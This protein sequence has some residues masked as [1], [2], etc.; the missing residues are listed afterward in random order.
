MEQKCFIFEGLFFVKWGPGIGFK[1]L[2]LN[3]SNP[4]GMA[5]GGEAGEEGLTGSGRENESKEENLY[6]VSGKKN[7][8][9]L[10]RGLFC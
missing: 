4:V 7:R 5:S 8:D 1:V 3:S 9:Y 10:L 6:V 2:L